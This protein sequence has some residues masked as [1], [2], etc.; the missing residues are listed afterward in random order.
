MVKRA[1]LA[2]FLAAVTAS[3]AHAENLANGEPVSIPAGTLLHCR[4]TQTLT[5][6]L[7]FQGD[8][9]SATV[10]EPIML[11]GHEAVP[12]GTVLHGR[13]V[14]LDKPGHIRGVGEMRLTTEQ[15]T[16]PDGRVFP[17]SAVLVTEYGADNAK[18]VGNE[19]LIKGPSSRP[20]EMGE[21][22]AGTAGGVVMGLIFG[23]PIVGAT[24]GFTA[25]A[26]DR[27]RRRGKD[28][29]LPA[30]TQLNYQLVRALDLTRNAPQTSAENHLHGAGN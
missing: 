1:L 25:A 30:G 21:I 3:L 12:V 15:L 22:G 7:N 5:T 16:F 4:V 9:F 14:Q 20:I 8:A 17:L 6:K 13:I 26:V 24:I 18:V 23:H 11:N 27:V 10:S 28:L 29:T 19:G 2:V